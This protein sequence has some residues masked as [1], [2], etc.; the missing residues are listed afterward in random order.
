MLEM[1]SKRKRK[2]LQNQ[3]C[4]FVRQIGATFLPLGVI[5]TED[6]DSESE[7]FFCDYGAL[8]PTCFEDLRTQHG[9]TLNSKDS[10]ISCQVCH[11]ALN[12]T[13]EIRQHLVAHIYPTH[14]FKRRKLEFKCDE[15]KI[16][17]NYSLH[18]SIDQPFVCSNC[19][20]S[21][22]TLLEL[23]SHVQEILFCEICDAHFSLLTSL[24]THLSQTHYKDHPFIRSKDKNLH[25]IIL[26]ILDGV[27]SLNDTVSYHPF[28]L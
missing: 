13:S 28:I 27:V 10:D 7:T 21:F 18:F 26:E 3:E 11:L 5:K 8:T 6:V 17:Y 12:N 22:K 15:A 9:E 25:K 20:R 24:A 16:S 14:P 1:P 23:K 19:Q 4:T 2:H